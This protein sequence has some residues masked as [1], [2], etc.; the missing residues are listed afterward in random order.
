[1][2]LPARFVGLMIQLIWNASKRP[3]VSISLIQVRLGGKRTLGAA[4]AD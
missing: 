1:M 4:A 2:E 3:N